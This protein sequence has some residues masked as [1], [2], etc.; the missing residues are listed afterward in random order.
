MNQCVQRGL[1]LTELHLS[2]KSTAKVCPVSQLIL[3]DA[4]SISPTLDLAG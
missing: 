3:A 1:A 4:K 2:Y